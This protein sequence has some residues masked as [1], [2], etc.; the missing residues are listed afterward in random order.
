[1][2]RIGKWVLTLGIVAVAPGLAAAASYP[3]QADT[4][5]AAATT[6]K[7]R[8]Q[9]VA[10]SIA[11]ALKKSQFH[12]YEIDIEYRNGL[13]TLRG[14]VSDPR[15]KVRASQIVSA[16]GGVQKV[17]NRLVVVAPQ[18]SSI[19]QV[20]ATNADVAAPA[21]QAS[22]QSTPAQTSGNQEKAM[23]IGHAL[24][25][26]GLS[27]YDVE[28]M[29]QNGRCVLQGMVGTMEQRNGAAQIAGSVPG[30]QAVSNQLRVQGQ[31]GP[32]GPAGPGPGAQPGPYGAPGSPYGGQ[33]QSPY[34]MAAYQAPPGVGAEGMPGPVPPMG[35]PMP[36]TGAGPQSSG[37]A[38]DNPNLP[39]SAWP[40][41]AQYPNYAAV[42]YP[43]QYSASAWP[44]I[45]PFYPYPQVPLNWRKVTLEWSDG[46]WD[47]NFDSRTD[48]WWWFLNPKN[49]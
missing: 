43:S 20:A 41:Y 48:R 11:L 16:V 37:P 33:P 3:W 26:A 21:Q 28:I 17:D 8:N 22:A 36:A 44:Y 40:S 2:V 46:H 47:L 4:D 1:M 13:A 9:Q 38:Y 39:Q 5:N 7:S 23:Q 29:F 32:A 10:E 14:K 42:T 6:Q 31:G 35:A 19:R 15:Q 34:Q 45:G 27:G 18:E 30:V 49:W 25:E 24:Q 12:G